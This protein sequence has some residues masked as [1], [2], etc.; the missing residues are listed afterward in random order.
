[1]GDKRSPPQ[2]STPRPIANHSTA[3]SQG[4]ARKEVMQPS[5]LPTIYMVVAITQKGDLP[6][7]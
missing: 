1:M 5:T 7:W 6:T 2:K 4:D 3:Q